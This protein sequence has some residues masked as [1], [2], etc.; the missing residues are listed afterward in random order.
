MNPEGDDFSKWQ[1]NARG[2]DLNHNYD[3]GF[4]KYKKLEAENG[5][6]EGAPTRYSGEYPES[7]PEVAALCNW[8]R[9]H[10]Y[11]RG[12]I[13]LH[14]QG[15]EVYYR[16]GDKCAP[17]APAVAYHVARLSGYRLSEAEGLASYGGLTDWCAADGKIPCFT[18]ECG[19]GIN[20]L[21]LSDVDPIYSDLRNLFFTFPS[22]V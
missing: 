13:T 11:L 14:T 12:I 20:P 18:L 8:I 7:E 6:T 22:L 19:R 16:S 17:N 9:Y 3:A 10:Q 15:E 21:P 4:W 5:I 1:S 2:V